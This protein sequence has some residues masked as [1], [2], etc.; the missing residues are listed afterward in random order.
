MISFCDK[1]IYVI[2]EKEV[3]REQIFSYYLNNVR[4]LLINTC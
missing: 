4:R 1:E 3:K 2:N